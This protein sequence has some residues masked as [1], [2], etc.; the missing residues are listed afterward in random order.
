M[1]RRR[2]RTRGRS[3]GR[4]GGRISRRQAL[5]A[6]ATALGGVGLLF[7]TRGFSLVSADRGADV[8][9][10]G[11]DTAAVGLDIAANVVA[12]HQTDLVD[13]TNRTTHSM[14]FQ[15]ALDTAGTTAPGSLTLA[16]NQTGTFQAN[17]ETSGPNATA[18]FRVLG[19]SGNGFS[20]EI[21][22]STTVYG[23]THVLEDRAQNNNGRYDF[24]FRIDGFPS[25]DYLE[26]EFENLDSAWAT[27]TRSTTN[28]E[29]TL[30]YTAGGTMQDTYEI[31]WT[32]YDSSGAILLQQ[33]VI[34]VADG[35]NPAGNEDLATPD[36]PTLESFTVTDTTKWNNTKY[37]VDYEVSN[38][39]TFQRV[40]VFFD[41]TQNSWA[42]TTKSSSSAPTGSVNYRQGGTENH[43]YE[44][45]VQVIDD[46]GFVVDSGSV[47]DV[48][49]GNNTVSWP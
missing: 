25:Y 31:T 27:D 20:V 11:D 3:R 30:T 12:D 33:T 42:D 45:T 48:A 23:L 35:T 17:V 43:Q 38:L 47:T 29:G 4:E 39:D 49:G 16:P 37:A 19:T 44:I 26:I 6:G 5:A 21:P 24:T 1:A 15:V 10:A 9:V 32:A 22:R 40:D 36:S 8:D 28:R 18:P 41:D 2:G 7:G 46:S 34:D 13:V 14:T